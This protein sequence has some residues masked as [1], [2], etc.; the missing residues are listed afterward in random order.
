M[1]RRIIIISVAVLIIAGGAVAVLYAIKRS[2]QLQNAVLKL[3]NTTNTSATSV[4]SGNTNVNRVSLPPDRQAIIF[5]ARN[6][7]ERYGSGSNQNGGSNLIEA[8]LYGTTLFNNFLHTQAIQAQQAAADPVYHGTISKALAFQVL[9]QSAT[10]ATVLVSTQQTIITGS[11]TTTATKDLLVDL[12]K[13]GS[14]WK[15][16]GAVWK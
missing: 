14:D 4:P 3:A 15:V 11:V 9:K 8:Q 7:T 5:V 13:I 16:S 1:R 12:Q 6:F 10:S 2:P